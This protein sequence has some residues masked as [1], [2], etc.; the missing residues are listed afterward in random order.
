MSFDET[1]I[2]CASPALCGIK[3]ASLFSMNESVFLSGEQKIKEWKPFFSKRRTYFV[4]LKK[5]DGRVLFFVYDARLLK[6]ILAE[7]SNRQYLASK[8]YPV[9]RGFQA[10][11]AELLHRLACADEFPHEVGLFLGYPL[12]DVIGF[13]TQQAQGSRYSGFW[14]VYGNVH[15]ARRIM[16]QY[17]TCSEKC[18]KLLNS[19]LSVPL[20]AEKYHSVMEATI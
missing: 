10:V 20:A 19:G 14:K 2:H 3:P 6:K 15:D 12:C 16:N 8:G 1:I 13:E 11:L 4:A 9:E 17:K 5:A 18:M 7:S